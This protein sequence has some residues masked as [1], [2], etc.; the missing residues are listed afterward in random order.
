MSLVINHL[1][2]RVIEEL[3]MSG[4]YDVYWYYDDDKVEVD[5]ETISADS[6]SDAAYSC[7]RSNGNRDLDFQDVIIIRAEL[8]GESD[9]Y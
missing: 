7:Q 4:F 3:I 8:L 5:V 9:E 1:V 6:E 2:N